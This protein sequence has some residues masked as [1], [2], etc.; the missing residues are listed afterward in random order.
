MGTIP[1]DRAKDQALAQLESIYDWVY[2]LDSDDLQDNLIGALESEEKLLT[3]C[4]SALS[5]TEH[6][7]GSEPNGLRHC[8]VLELLTA[9]IRTAKGEK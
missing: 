7:E 9:A 6:A 1:V 3:A 2:D 4:E 5:Y 8:D